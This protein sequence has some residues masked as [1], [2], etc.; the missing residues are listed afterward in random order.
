MYRIF[1]TI[2]SLIIAPENWLIALVVWWVLSKSAVVKKRL[3]TV[4]VVLILIFGNDVLY[5]KLANAWQPKLVTL[6]D[7]ASY[8]AGIVLGGSSS[9]DKYRNG[10]LNAAADRF[11]EICVLYKTGKIKK[12]IISGGSNSLNG[13]K[14]ARF[15]YKKM[16]ELG[17]PAEDII[18]EDSSKNTFENASFSKRKI[19]SLQLKPP[20]ILVTSAMHMPRSQRVFTRVGIPV[21][22]YPS[23]FKVFEKDFSFTDYFIPSLSTLFSWNSFLKEVVGVLGYKLMNRA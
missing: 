6:P 13:P 8:E 16:I 21:I 15:Q 10:Y 20:F 11:V 19:D 18:V 1:S 9:F 14:D 23:D 5:N 3:M 2:V 12:I 17:I 4:M 22:P 7:S